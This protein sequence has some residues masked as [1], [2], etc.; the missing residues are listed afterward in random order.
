MTCL[1]SRVFPNFPISLHILFIL[2]L[3]HVRTFSWN[4]HRKCVKK[5]YFLVKTGYWPYILH[6]ICCLSCFKENT[7][8]IYKLLTISTL[9]YSVFFLKYIIA[10]KFPSCKIAKVWNYLTFSAFLDVSKCSLHVL[11]EKLISYHSETIL[12]Y[13]YYFSYRR[14]HGNY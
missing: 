9:S 14:H 13:Y 7:R 3:F 4:K 11:E 1:S 6:S 12:L 2:C 5:W 8:I 10:K